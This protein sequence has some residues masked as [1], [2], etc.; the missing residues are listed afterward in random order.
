MEDNVKGFIEISEECC[1]QVDPSSSGGDPR[2]GMLTVSDDSSAA[3]IW[4]DS[5]S[6]RKWVLEEKLHRGKQNLPRGSD[7]GFLPWPHHSLDTYGCESVAH[8]NM[9]MG[10]SIRGAVVFREDISQAKDWPAALSAWTS[11]ALG[12]SW[13]F[14][15]L[16]R[17]YHMGTD[18]MLV[19]L[20]FDWV[21]LI[22]YLIV[23]CPHGI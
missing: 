8:L 6:Q 18:L 1:G 17:S 22:I 10:V 4:L 2:L 23:Q 5:W 13:F 20:N 12:R 14:R 3:C 15:S 16:S 21:H 11:A 9:I 7:K 19:E